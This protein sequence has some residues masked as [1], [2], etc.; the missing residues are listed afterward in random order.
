MSK[1]SS[2][3]RFGRSA[4]RSGLGHRGGPVTIIED[5]V[6]RSHARTARVAFYVTAVVVGL[7][8]AAIAAS[9]VP[10][11]A[12]L[13][14]GGVLGW[15]V[16]V[17][18]AAVITCWPVLRVLWW[19]APEI[20]LTLL[21]IFGWSLLT[22]HTNLLVR[23]V[24]LALLVGV[25]AA[26]PASRR[27]LIA[28]AWC[29]IVRH[30]L[31]VCFHEF[32]ITNRSGTL[33][34]ILWA[35]PTPTG[36]RVWAWLRPGLSLH[37]LQ[38]RVDHIAVACWADTVTVEAASDSNA[39]LVRI[40]IKRRTVLTGTVRPPLAALPGGAAPTDVAPG[41]DASPRQ[42][43]TALD[44]PDVP[45]PDTTATGKAAPKVA[46][47]PN[48]TASA[49]TKTGKANAGGQA[50]QTAASSGGDDVSDWI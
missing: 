5:R 44:L 16:G 36:E 24:A 38:T 48:G 17:I 10:A 8:A 45:N 22:G 9:Y 39:A 47:T 35:K 20:C 49:K 33:P 19:W 21:G 27:F 26:I 4:Y 42:A 3:R 34:L 15:I 43:P 32:I 40:D 6:S 12:A 28:C 25:P 1:V 7:L 41:T 31:R 14:I 50:P 13:L 30:R 2:A 11:L 46:P 37:D 18:V 23:L 29:L